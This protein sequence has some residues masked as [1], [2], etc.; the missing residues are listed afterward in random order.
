MKNKENEVKKDKAIKDQKIEFM[1][2]Q[3]QDLK[4]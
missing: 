1:E 4:D 2:M 3:I